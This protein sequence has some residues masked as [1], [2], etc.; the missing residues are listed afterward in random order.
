MTR[1]WL[2]RLLFP[3]GVLATVGPC[4]LAIVVIGPFLLDTGTYPTPP[5]LTVQN[6]TNQ[7]VWI[8]I[9]NSQHYPILFLPHRTF[10][11]DVHLRPHTQFT[12]LS[13]DQPFPRRCSWSEVHAHQPLVIADDGAHCQDVGATPASS[14]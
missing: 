1:K 5:Q 7:D 3:L 2:F 6:D 12:T 14:N 10:T 8:D 4:I 9:A 13:I 11:A